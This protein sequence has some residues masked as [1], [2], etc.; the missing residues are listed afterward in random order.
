METFIDYLPITIYKCY[1]TNVINNHLVMKRYWYNR[2][3][4]VVI[5]K[6]NTVSG[7]NFSKD[8]NI[9]IINSLKVNANEWIISVG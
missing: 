6:K 3:T 8:W 7:E 5:R 2:N 9:W 4:G 1:K